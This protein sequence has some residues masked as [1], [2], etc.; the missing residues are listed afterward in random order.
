M[1]IKRYTVA[2]LFFMFLV[3]W[4]VFGY[5]SQDSIAIESFGLNLPILPIAVWVLVPVAFLYLASVFHMSYYSFLSNL[6]FKKYQKDYD[7]FLES[8]ADAYLAKPFRSHSFKSDE[9]KIL[10][11]LI[12]HSDISAHNDLE[13]DNEKLNAILALR[14]KIESGEIV[15]LKEYGLSDENPLV[16]KNNHNKFRKNELSIDTI[17][18]KSE[19]F[20]EELS[21]AAY[22]KF[23]VDAQLS[24][25]LSYK[26]FMSKEALFTILKRINGDENILEISNEALIELFTSIELDSKDYISAS[27]LL[28]SSMVPD[29]RMRFFELLAEKVELANAAYLYT[30][31]DLEMIEKADEILEN[32]LD[33]ECLNFKAY[34]ELK[35]STN[36]FNINLFV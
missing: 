13:I 14:N 11:K 33:D 24:D 22:Q 29:Q 28:A 6:K 30:L 27:K 12:D 25:I 26:K 32:S 31:F 5:I 1:Y 23:V 2:T 36:K 9:Y 19:K 18:T 4:Y 15:S 8:I 34:R 21:R 10:G 17:L 3:G 16:I 7:K 35:N 20:D